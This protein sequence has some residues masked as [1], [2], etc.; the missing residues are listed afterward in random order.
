VPVLP[1]LA[2]ALDAVPPGQPT[3]LVTEFGRPFAVAGF[4]NWFSDRCREAGLTGCSAHGLRKAAAARL[5]EA[6]ATEAELMAVFGWEKA[7]MA[8][9]YT[10]AARRDRMAWDAMAKLAGTGSEPAIGKPP[11]TFSKSRRKRNETNG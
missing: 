3:Y 6:G 11:V 10:R 8:T 7:D 5:A 1:A 9:L 2:R 4:G